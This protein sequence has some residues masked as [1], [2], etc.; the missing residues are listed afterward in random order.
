[1][2]EANG[3]CLSRLGHDTPC[4]V[5]GMLNLAIAMQTATHE[6][7]AEDT[8][9]AAAET[10]LQEAHTK[11]ESQAPEAEHHVTEPEH[12]VAEVEAGPSDRELLPRMHNLRL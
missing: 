7:S 8:E 5:E 9:E 12:R 10:H 1:M 2:C 11:L 3:G 6:P 4:N